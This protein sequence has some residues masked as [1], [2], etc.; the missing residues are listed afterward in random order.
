MS[1]MIRT[2]LFRFVLVALLVV[3]GAACDGGSP[4]EPPDDGPDVSVDRYVEGSLRAR[5]EAIQDAMPRRG[6][7]G[8]VPPTSD[9]LDRWRSVVEAL[10]DSDTTAVDAQL[11]EHFPSYALVRFT[12]AGTG[13]RYYLLQETPSVEKGWGSVL[14]RPAPERNLAIH[15]PH[16]VFDLDTHREGVDVFQQTGA[17]VLLLAGTHRCANQAVS[18]C[19]GTSSVCGDGRYHISDM[20]HVVSAP[21]QATHAVFTARFPDMVSLSLHGNGSADCETVFLSNGTDAA[22]QPALQALQEALSQQGVRVGV[23]GR[24]SCALVGSTNVQGRLT[25]GSAQPCTEAAATATGN[26]IHVEQRRA[27]REDPA[28][29]AALIDAINAVF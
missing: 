29:Y 14:V 18:P 22:M 25:N 12:E 20:A 23:P 16:P 28:A 17:R 7:E 5:V 2:L 4:A 11:A 8:F 6:S 3:G 13:Q 24:S 15:A 27:F 26:F 10:I 19:D 1:P 9:E 21:F